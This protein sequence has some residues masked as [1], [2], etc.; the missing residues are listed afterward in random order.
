MHSPST[1]LAYRAAARLA[2]AMAPG[3]ARS[4]PKLRAALAGRAGVLDRLAEWARGARDPARPL[5]WMH[6]SSVG[7]GLQ[8]EIVLKTLRAAHP[9]WQIAYT[10]FSPSAEALARRQPADVADYLPWD[11]PR[12]VTA[13]LDALR[14]TAVVFCKLD[15]WPEL[16]TRAAARGVGVGLVAATVSRQSGRLRWPARRLLRPGYA[17]VTLAGAVAEDDAARLAELGV[18]RERIEITGDPRY[19]SA[20]DRV[21][22]IPPDEPLL[23]S[24]RGGPTLVAGSTWPEDEEALLRAFA[25][26]RAARPDARLILVPHEPTPEHLARLEELAR[27]AG[28]EAPA[29]LG[30]SAPTAALLVMDRVGGLATLYAGA[31]IAYVGGGYGTAG[32]HSVVEPAACGV[33]V[34]F[35]PRWRSSRDAAVLLEHRAAA[36]V[37][38]KFPDWLD[39]DSGSTH[40][41]AN[42]LA[43]IWLALLRN[44]GHARAA[45]RRALA[46]VEE[47]LGGAARSA[48]LVERILASAR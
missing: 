40:A 32:L 39:L 30:G 44:P 42:P 3:L 4:R 15:L 12:D 28:L 43:A 48:R 7:E 41:G 47:G 19:D 14:P 22:A 29:R 8:A 18:P 26:V 34:L 23:A 6:A 38:P 45:G 27:S 46:C 20:A 37:S 1:S 31:T 24:C 5:L 36:V 21:H 16:A 35:G 13:A 17:A 9:A 11:R 2:A 33:P 10:H 25:A